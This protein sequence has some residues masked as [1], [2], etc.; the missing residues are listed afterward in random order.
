MGSYYIH[1]QNLFLV[2]MPRIRAELGKK[3]FKYFSPYVWNQH[4]NELHLK[5]LFL[6]VSLNKYFTFY[7]SKDLHVNVFDGLFDYTAELV[8]G[9][10]FCLYML[11]IADVL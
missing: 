6:W 11:E 9:L 8:V 1:S 10:F 3:G 5:D 7:I 2:T 4:Q